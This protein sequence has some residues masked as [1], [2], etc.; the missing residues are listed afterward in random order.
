[1]S[2]IDK[3]FRLYL[4]S[5]DE[6]NLKGITMDKYVFMEQNNKILKCRIVFPVK[7]KLKF[8]L[9]AR[10]STENILK[11]H[12]KFCFTKLENNLEKTK[13]FRSRDLYSNFIFDSGY[14]TSL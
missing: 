8:E 12:F 10:K 14:V 5:K 7:G 11:V 4:S 3:H 2:L 9:F 1:M 13:G 6:Q